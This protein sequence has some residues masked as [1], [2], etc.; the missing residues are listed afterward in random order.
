M[1]IILINNPIS[2]GYKH[3]I[4]TYYLQGKLPTVTKG[5]YGGELTKDT[6]TLEH[7]KPVS[8]GGK[9]ELKNLVLSEDV[10]NWSRGNR[11]LTDVFN[12]EAFETYCEEFKGIK[13][14]YFNGDEYIRQITKTIERLL[15]QG[16]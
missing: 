3:L 16:K 2:F 12:K 14:P 13:L 9:T 15:K 4:K 7:L 1:K 5:F 8:K 10:K 11:P 6:V